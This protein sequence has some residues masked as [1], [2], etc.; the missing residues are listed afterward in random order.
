MPKKSEKKKKT[1]PKKRGCKRKKGLVPGDVVVPLFKM[2][3]IE[4]TKT[5]EVL[6]LQPGM[7]EGLEGSEELIVYDCI[8]TKDG[9]SLFS[10]EEVCGYWCVDDFKKNG[11]KKENM[12]ARV[13]KM[14]EIMTG[15]SLIACRAEVVKEISVFVATGLNTLYNQK[16]NETLSMI[17]ILVGTIEGIE[18]FVEARNQEEAM[19]EKLKKVLDG[20]S[21]KFEKAA[22]N[23]PMVR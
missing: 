2:E 12:R 15:N 8:D 9:Y 5:A 21:G 3:D 7:K 20:L 6:K 16:Y 1:T 10:I 11:H 14:N 22:E 18:L 17:E 13:D 4:G 23:D 19:K